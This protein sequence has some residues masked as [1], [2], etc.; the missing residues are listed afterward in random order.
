MHVELMLKDRATVEAFEAADR[1]MDAVVECRRMF[2]VP[3]TSIRVA[4]A[5][6]R[7]TRRST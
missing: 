3:T 5:D 4:V 7:R 6:R 1:R 2:G